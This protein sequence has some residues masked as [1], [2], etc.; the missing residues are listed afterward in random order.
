MTDKIMVKLKPIIL[1]SI[2][3][4]LFFIFP[5]SASEITVTATVD[6]TEATMDDQITLSVAVNGAQ[7]MGD[8]VLP[9]LQGF[10]VM[11]SGTSSEVKIINGTLSA[12][13]SFNYI[14]V[15]QKEGDFTIGQVQ[16]E[17][18]GKVYRTAPIKIKVLSLSG[19]SRKDS[20][21]KEFF[22]TAEI[23]NPNPYMNEQIVYTIRFFR[24]I[25]VSEASIEKPAFEGFIAEELG[26]ER[27]LSK[28]INGEQYLVYEI[29]T[30][31]F[32]LKAGKLEIFSSRIKFG[33]VR[34]SKSRGFFDDPFFGSGR[35]EQK[36][37]STKPIIVNVKPLPKENRP[38]D[39]NNLVGNFK[40]AA[41]LSKNEIKV[42][43]S[44]T[45][46]LEISGKGNIR[47]IPEPFLK[48]SS[49]FKIYND[50]PRVEIGID[51]DSLIGEKIFKKAIIPLK[52][53]ILNIPP[54]TISFF[55]PETGKYETISSKKIVFTGLPGGEDERLRIAEGFK[56]QSLQESIKVLKRDIL[57]INTSISSL[58]DQRLN[59]SDPLYIAFSIIPFLSYLSCLVY[60]KRSDRYM[61]DIKFARNR[62]AIG[63]AKKR[64]KEA[65]KCR[66]N[67]KDAFFTILS[68]TVREYLGDKL[69][70]AGSALTPAEIGERL[71]TAGINE[72]TVE[73][74]KSF[75]ENLEYKKF[76]SG[77]LSPEEKKELLISGE[78]LLNVLERDFRRFPI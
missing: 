60:K 57:P 48:E 38:K 40:I 24:K 20:D 21:S 27:E 12:S 3:I 47:N 29:R 19:E 61:K 32:P 10:Q 59:L 37:L 33:I 64:L 22:L 39:F 74:V 56:G 5:A 76:V 45:L 43:E 49:E 34:R 53:G 7:R 52:T 58:K 51:G 63:E 41:S 14:L 36:I 46:D 77:G 68:K 13:K 35:I 9:S 6:K 73:K 1:A 30:V 26:K 70:V 8:P 65:R 78:E 72:K 75:L 69:N 28:V 17:V 23:N 11:S 4:F 18:Q 42:G 2:F 16:V 62:R 15:P 50:Q 31:L 55:N 66:E 54:V 67:Y 71:G 25:P 44:A